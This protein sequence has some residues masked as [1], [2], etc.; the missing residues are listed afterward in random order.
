[1]FLYGIDY[2]LGGA[3]FLALLKYIYWLLSWKFQLK[4][5]FLDLLMDYIFV[6]IFLVFQRINIQF[7]MSQYV[8][9]A[10]LLILE[11]LILPGIYFLIKKRLLQKLSLSILKYYPFLDIGI[12]VLSF[13]FT[14]FLFNALYVL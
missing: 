13:L 4:W 8:I 9:I 7:K 10:L 1:M 12:L 2:I 6:L 11:L 5:Y 3:I 14:K